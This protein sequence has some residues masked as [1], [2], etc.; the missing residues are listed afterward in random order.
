M[1]RIISDIFSLTKGGSASKDILPEPEVCKLCDMAKEILQV[2]NVCI[3]RGRERERDRRAMGERYE[4]G[5]ARVCMCW[6]R[7]SVCL[8]RHSCSAR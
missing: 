5:G 7:A 3:E 1:D 8:A 4:R 2:T 6:E